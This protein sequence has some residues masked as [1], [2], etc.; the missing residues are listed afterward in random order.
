MIDKTVMKQ[1]EDIEKSIAGSRFTSVSQYL[2]E[3][4][5]LLKTRLK[6]LEQ[7]ECNGS[8][9]ERLKEHKQLSAFLLANF[10][11]LFDYYKIKY[12]SGRNV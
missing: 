8:L 5:E 3:K 2:E 10:S 1:L 11:L 9:S 6:E 7:F 12:R 4:I